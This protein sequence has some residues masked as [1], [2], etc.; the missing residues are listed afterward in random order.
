M[1]LILYAG[2]MDGLWLM[3]TTV[4]KASPHGAIT[5]QDDDGNLFKVNGQ[6]LKVYLEPENLDEVDLIEFF[7]FND[8]I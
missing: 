3:L 8:P 2:Y 7:Q 1:E 6:R 4:N 5:L